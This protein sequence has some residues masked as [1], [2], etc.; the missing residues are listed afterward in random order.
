MWILPSNDPIKALQQVAAEIRALRKG[1]D[2][3]VMCSGEIVGYWQTTDYID[4]LL[5]MADECEQ[6][7]SNVANETKEVVIK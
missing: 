1:N 6:V 4:F 2:R 3:A 5:E 7:A